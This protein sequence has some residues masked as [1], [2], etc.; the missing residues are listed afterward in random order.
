MGQK[1]TLPTKVQKTGTRFFVKFFQFFRI[2]IPYRIQIQDHHQVNADP[3]PQHG[4][5]LVIG[6]KQERADSPTGRDS[7]AEFCVENPEIF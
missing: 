5:Q 4:L 2:S 1:H 3:D 6:S 7:R